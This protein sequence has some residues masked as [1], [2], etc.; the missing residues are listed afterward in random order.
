VMRAIE[1]VDFSSDVGNVQ[2][3]SHASRIENFVGILS[4]SVILVVLIVDGGLVT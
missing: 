4:R 1:N 3:L 2:L